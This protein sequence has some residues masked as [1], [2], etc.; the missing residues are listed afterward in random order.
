MFL[1]LYK[2]CNEE[3]ELKFSIKLIFIRNNLNN[4]KNQRRY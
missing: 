1:L 2:M 4:K 3:N